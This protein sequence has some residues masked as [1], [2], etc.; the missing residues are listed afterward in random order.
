LSE[1]LQIVKDF[2]EEVDPDLWSDGYTL[3]YHTEGFTEWIKFGEHILWHSEDCNSEIPIRRHIV[4]EI[5]AY[6]RSL[7]MTRRLIGIL[8]NTKER[9]IE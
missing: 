1:A 4:I 6:I 9:I 7:R 5:D 8:G 3:T 2:N